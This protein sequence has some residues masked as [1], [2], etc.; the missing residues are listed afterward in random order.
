MD[1]HEFN[2]MFRIDR[3]KLEAYYQRV[4]KGLKDY[5]LIS[6][7]AYFLHHAQSIGCSENEIIDVLKYYKDKIKEG[8]NLFDLAI[9]WVRAGKIRSEYLKHLGSSYF[10]SLDVAIDDCLFYFFLQFDEGLRKLMKEDIK[11]FE[12]SALHAIFFNP[13]EEKIDVH[14][15]LEK[16]KLRI[17]TFYHRSEKIDTRIITLRSG[18]SEIMKK[19]Y[20]TIK[21]R[22]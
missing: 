3:E 4:K 7:L 1:D 13:N 21:R 18:I 5:D 10:P 14:N 17:P 12:L 15:V 16:L 22:T 6:A 20:E 19:D 9:E 8:K 11:E 2:Q